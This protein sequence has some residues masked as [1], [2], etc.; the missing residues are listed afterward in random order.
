MHS[1]LGYLCS[2]DYAVAAI[3]AGAIAFIVWFFFGKA[4]TRAEGHVHDHAA[5]QTTE[6]E[7]AIGG[8]HCP[9]CLLAIERVLGRL[10]GVQAVATNFDAERAYVTFDPAR[11]HA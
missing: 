7:L 9:S 10:E 8:I 5:A 3:G 6:V 11:H 4:A 1:Y 2:A